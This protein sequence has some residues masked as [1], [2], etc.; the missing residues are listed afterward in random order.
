MTN[1]SKYHVVLCLVI[2]LLAQSVSSARADTSEISNK[3]RAYGTERPRAPDGWVGFDWE[4]KRAILFRLYAPSEDEQALIGEA[5]ET[6]HAQRPSHPRRLL[7]FY[8]CRY[9]HASIATGNESFERVGT[10]TGAYTATLTDDPADINAENLA[11]Y[12]ALLLN[13]TTDFDVTVGPRGQKAILDYVRSGK[14]LIGIHAAA[15]SCKKWKTGQPLIN[16]IF[17]CHPWLPKGTWAF[18]LESPRHPLNAA[19]GNSGFW[20]RDEVYIYRPGSP[21]R[22]KSRVLVSL[23]PTK[24]HNREAK[25]LH[26]KL[27]SLASE[28]VSRPVAWIHEFGKGR[29]F[30]SNLGHNNTTFWQPNVLQH[31]L[32][33]IQ[34]ALGDIEADATQSSDLGEIKYARAPK[35]GK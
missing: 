15:D 9:P 19:F 30:Y 13:N 23:D 26:E 11:N 27:L 12:D 34:Y 31:Y 4:K 5:V 35:R 29:V 3:V 17:Q 1:S 32:G 8:Q 20:H 28:D 14:G 2:C 18:Q 22:A 6:L 16:G 10:A 21:S 7:V 33:G 25:E 24:P